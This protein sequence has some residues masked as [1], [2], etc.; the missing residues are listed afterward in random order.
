[1]QEHPKYKTKEILTFADKTQRVVTNKCINRG[2][3]TIMPKNVIVHMMTGKEAVLDVFTDANEYIGDTV[4]ILKRY[5]T[6]NKVYLWD[7]K[8]PFDIRTQQCYIA[9]SKDYRIVFDPSDLSDS[10]QP[11]KDTFLYRGVPLHL[12]FFNHNS[13]KV[14]VLK[15]GTVISEKQD[16]CWDLHHFDKVRVFET[17]SGWMPVTDL[18]HKVYSFL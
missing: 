8:A 2:L 14:C 15:D 16:R 7:G 5:K 9:I 1:V 18:L 10:I 3:V 6:C 12:Q 17:L 4:V 13:I 11:L